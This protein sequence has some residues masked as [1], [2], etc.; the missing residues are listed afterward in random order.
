VPTERA[1]G[2]PIER[3]GNMASFYRANQEKQTP[4]KLPGD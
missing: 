4:L 1:A 3:I 2:D